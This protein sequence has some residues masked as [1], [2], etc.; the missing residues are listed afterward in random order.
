MTRR[1]RPE[2]PERPRLLPLPENPG[3]PNHPT[4]IHFGYQNGKWRGVEDPEQLDPEP[5][6]ATQ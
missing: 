1:K 4:R 5:P 3:P 2:R 6:K